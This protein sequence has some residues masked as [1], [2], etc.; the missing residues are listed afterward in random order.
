MIQET[1]LCAFMFAVLMWICVV[2]YKACSDNHTVTVFAAVA[3]TTV[4]FTVSAAN[5]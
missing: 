2:M 1:C 4:Q 3:G 5:R